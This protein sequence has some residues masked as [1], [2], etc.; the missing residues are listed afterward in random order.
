M[1]RV[2]NITKRLERFRKIY[3]DRSS[4]KFATCTKCGKKTEKR[5]E[6]NRFRGDETFMCWPCWNNSRQAERDYAQSLVGLLDEN[7]EVIVDMAN[8]GNSNT[9]SVSIR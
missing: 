3:F 6:I 7:N 9:E 8:F 4:G 5:N 1:R 2:E